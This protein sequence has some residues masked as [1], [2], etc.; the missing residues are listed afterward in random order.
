MKIA[1]MGAGGVGGYFGGLLAKAGN[2]V[3]LV[4][5]GQHAQAIQEKGL[6][7]ESAASGDFTVHPL[8]APAPD[9]AWQ[10]DLVLF[11]VKGY[12][13]PEAIE[14]IRPMVGGHTTVLTLQNGVANG[15]HLAN[16][17]GEERVLLGAAYIE[18][19]LKEPG[20]VHQTG[21]PC[22]ILFGEVDGSRTP[23]AEAV[24]LALQQAEITVQ[25]SDNILKELWNKFIF[26]CA[27]SGMT[28]IARASLG[29]VMASPETRD[30]LVRVMREAETVGRARG[31]GLDV[32]VV[33][34]T[35]AHFDEFSDELRS[36]MQLD[37]ERGNRL[38]VEALN[39]T[40]ARFGRETGIETP[41]N[42]FIHS[43]LKLADDR[44]R[45]RASP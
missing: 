20:V 27:L 33:E 34:Q 11:A 13:T 26:I 38:E 14:T 3:L 5:R 15:E 39:G 7:V 21:G 31:V 24:L 16:A 36:S 6:R 23:R 17:F 42:D 9:G 8:V 12:S 32:D 22:R 44:A 1:V 29:E 18:T 40:V 43:C 37:L 2:D 28:S 30:L 41:V 45:L 10:P 25:I 35:V 4:A 19:H